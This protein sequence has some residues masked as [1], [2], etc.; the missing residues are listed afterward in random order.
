MVRYSL[1]VLLALLCGCE[2]ASVR[3]VSDMPHTLPENPVQLERFPT[4]ELTGFTFQGDAKLEVSR[5]RV[6][7]YRAD[8]DSAVKLQ[9]AIYAIPPGWDDM[10]EARLVAGHFGQ[11]RESVVQHLLRS[12]GRDLELLDDRLVEDDALAYPMGYAQL[13]HLDQMPGTFYTVMLTARDPL[14]IR[15]EHIDPNGIGIDQKQALEIMATVSASL[16]PDS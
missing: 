4:P 15:M 16:F 1:L 13:R 14:F 5:Q 3:D 2:T 9:L 10:P 12:V 7:L 11:V 6:F 8:D